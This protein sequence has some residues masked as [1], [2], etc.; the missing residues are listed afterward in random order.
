MFT[1]HMDFVPCIL[2]GK[3]QLFQ[4]QKKTL[5]FFEVAESCGKRRAGLCMKT[6]PVFSILSV[7]D[8]Y[9]VT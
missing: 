6:D 1:W 7:A 5:I 4:S 2:L 9:P 8:C 3:G